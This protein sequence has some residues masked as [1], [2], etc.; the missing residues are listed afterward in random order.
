MIVGLVTSASFA[1]RE[2][3]G[4]RNKFTMA[5]LA[6]AALDIYIVITYDPVQYAPAAVRAGVTP[7][8][9][10]YHQI[11]VLRPLTFAIL[12]SVFA[13]LI[14]VTA[15]N[16]LFFMPPTQAEQVEQLVDASL[17]AVVQASSKLHAL[18]VTRNA[19][20]RDRTLKERDDA[21]WRTV[22]ST[23]GENTGVG[24]GDTSVWEEE[25]V[26]RAMSRAMAG[27]GD[28]DLAKVGV[29]ANEYVN[30]VTAILDES[31]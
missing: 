7:P 25:E 31:Q 28:V 3:A 2:A 14:Y 29:N 22:V 10:L 5:G 11:S 1:G 24:N 13:G 26:V 8:S 23:T 20:V 12:D 9:S 15:T 18:S 16:R 30:G 21:Y 17:P 27:Q 19:V 4:W 6:L